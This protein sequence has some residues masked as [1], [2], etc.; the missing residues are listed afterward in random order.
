M[1]TTTAAVIKLAAPVE[2]VAK[3]E[4]VKTEGTKKEHQRDENR[5][6]CQYD[7]NSVILPHKGLPRLRDSEP[8]NAK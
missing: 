6:G 7:E 1:I 4:K 3:Y 2:P 5:Y 8:K